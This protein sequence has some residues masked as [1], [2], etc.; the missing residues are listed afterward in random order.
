[1][2]ELYEFQKEDV[3]KLSGQPNVIN[4]SDM[5]CGKTVV[6]A[7]LDEVRRNGQKKPTLIIA[8]LSGTMNTWRRHYQL[9]LP[10]L[11]GIVLETKNKDAF[12]KAL[13]RTDWYDYYIVHWDMVARL[14]KELS[15]VG[16][17]HI[18]ADECHRAKNRKAQTTRALWRIKTTYK[19][20]LSGTPVTNQP[21]DLW[22]ILHW[23]YPNQW[24]GYW[25]FF[26][27]FVLYTDVEIPGRP[28]YHKP[29]GPNPATLGKLHREIEPFYVRHLKRGPCCAKH[30]QG[31][32]SYLPDKTYAEPI[33]VDLTPKQR[34]AYDQMKKDMIAWVGDQ[35]D[36]PI[37]APIAIA[38]LVRLQQLA[39]AHA[40]IDEDWNIQLIEPSSKLDALMDLLEDNPDQQF[41][42]FS[43]FS[44]MI[45]LLGQRLTKK[46]ISHGLFT[47]G[48]KPDE[49]FR[50]VQ[51]F[52]AGTLRVFAG[53]IKAGGVGLDLYSASSIVFL[54]RSWSPAE[55]LQAEDRLWRHGQQNA[56]TVYDIM[57]RNTVDLGRNQRIAMKWEWIRQLL[58]DK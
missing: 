18:I 58:G 55:N 53:T 29:L 36:K 44:K 47:G 43:Q 46:G 1:L 22:S 54:D 49:R 42:V 30:P 37:A 12:I 31:V 52:Q 16:W 21:Q 6:A 3:E 51:D 27:E 8:P 34:R 13:A 32:M 10:H 4:A 23:L 35:G 39:L 2:I 14:E 56:V 33:W 45:N 25:K 11:K 5:G 15:R 50:I 17:N 20:A 41:V 28:A 48:T 19:T 9:H 7:A 57:A 38:K 40:D 24:R 26:K